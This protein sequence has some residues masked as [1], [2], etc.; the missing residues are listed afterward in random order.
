M[1]NRKKQL[2][3]WLKEVLHVVHIDLQPIIGDASFRRYY[4]LP[5][6][7]L[8]VMDAPPEHE[9]CHAFVQVSALLK[10][11]DVQVPDILHQ[12][13]DHGFLVISDL[14]D[15]LY[16][17]ALNHN[18]ADNLYHDAINALI[19]IQNI[20]T[21]QSLPVYNT[22][23]L[24]QEMSLFSDWL[25][26]KHIKCHYDQ[27]KLAACFDFIRE[28]AL[29]QPTIMVHR[30]FHSRNL[31]CSEDNNPAVLDYQDAVLG[32]ISYDLVSLLKDCYIQW[33]PQQIDHWFNYYYTQ[34]NHPAFSQQQLKIW[35]NLMGVQRHLKAS[36]IFARLYHRD[37]KKSYLEYIPRTL[38]YILALTN[39]YPQ[40]YYLYQLIEDHI[41]PQ[42]NQPN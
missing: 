34:L 16:I 6:H 15:D 18:T 33:Q 40:L 21:V 17:D 27:Q 22:M 25:L 37:N 39:D 12:N 13:L 24:Q 1:N 5:E 8:I 3:D 38:S 41:M 7:H 42:L 26:G 28:S 32:P 20:H 23:L 30:D 36:G 2:K 10:K 35:F 14:G 11:A 31:M 19:K 29:S 9:D 4:R